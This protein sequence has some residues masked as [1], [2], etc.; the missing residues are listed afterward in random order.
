[1][2]KKKRLKVNNSNFKKKFNLTG[3]SYYLTITK[4]NIDTDTQTVKSS[5]FLFLRETD[6]S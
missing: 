3:S 4:I 1:M 2:F 6:E 5:L